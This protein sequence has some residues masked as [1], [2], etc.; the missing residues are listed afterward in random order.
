M[1][2]NDFPATWIKS[3]FFSPGF[4]SMSIDLVLVL[5]HF[6][7]PRYAEPM[8]DGDDRRGIGGLFI[9]IIIPF[10]FLLGVLAGMISVNSSIWMSRSKTR[11]LP[12][13]AVVGYALIL[14]EVGLFVIGMLQQNQRH[15]VK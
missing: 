9:L 15:S 10:W 6:F 8:I 1:E 2:E 5:R 3:G 4:G 13:F 11:L 7:V 12:Y 14:C